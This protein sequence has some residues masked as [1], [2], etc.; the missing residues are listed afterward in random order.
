MT[1][2]RRL[3][4]VVVASLLSLALTTPS[5]GT[6]APTLQDEASAA[7][8]ATRAVS[9]TIRVRDGRHTVEATAG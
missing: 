6:A 9:L 2:P 7:L 1:T 8:D 4:A 3:A 5:S